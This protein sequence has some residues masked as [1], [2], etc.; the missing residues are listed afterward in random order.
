[1][2]KKLYKCYAHVFK[3]INDNIL[4]LDGA[5]FITDYEMG[6]R[7]AIQS[8]FPNAKLFGCWFHF[9]QAVRRQVV[10]KYKELAKYIRE[11]KKASLEYHKLLVLPLLPASHIVSSFESIKEAILEFDHHF[12]F[13]SFLGYYEI[14]WIK[15]VNHVN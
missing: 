7:K 9:T 11:N 10:M 2:N 1:M 5:V 3:Y 13:M 15:K 8:E 6:L 14:Q 4:Q 12:N